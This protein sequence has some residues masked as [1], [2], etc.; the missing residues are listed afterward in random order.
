M[1]IKAAICQ[2]PPV[3]LDKRA[4]MSAAL[5]IVEEAAGEGARLIT[6]PE[7]FLPGYPTWAW[8]LR[9]GGDMALGNEI[10]RQLR[11]NAID[12]GSGELDPLREAASQHGMVIVMGMHELDTEFSGST[13]FNTAVVIGDDG[14]VLNRHRKLMPTN[15]ERMVW[16][17]GDA[18]GLRV[19][20]TKFGRL[21]CLICWENYMPL[22]RYALYAQR[23]DILVAIT[24]DC[25]DLWAASMRHIAKEGGCWV[26]SS[27]TALQGSDVPPSFPGRAQLY[28]DE[29]WINP[30]DAIAVKPGGSVAA[31]PLHEEK[32]ILYVMIDADAARASRKSLDPSGHYARS[33]VFQ[34]TVDR[35]QKAP[36]LFQDSD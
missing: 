9:P 17:A 20:E 6:F 23:M 5:A 24:W 16:G 35:R 10:H 8:R 31:G 30:G 7:A 29:E 12:I 21:G 18:R 27:A 3:L 32:S 14:T 19:V 34:L 28:K 2:R 11:L 15:P 4:S 22:A 36:A 13:L 33:D 25:G 1:E 26:L